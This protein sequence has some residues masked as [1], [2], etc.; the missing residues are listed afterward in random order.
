MDVTK[1]RP[2]KEA[3]M[4][5]GRSVHKASSLIGKDRHEECRGI[6]E[7]ITPSFMPSSTKVVTGEAVLGTYDRLAE[8]FQGLV[9]VYYSYPSIWKS[10]SGY[11]GFGRTE[12]VTESGPPKTPT[13]D[14]GLHVCLTWSPKQ[15]VQDI[16][17]TL[18]SIQCITLFR[19]AC[20]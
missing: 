1:F 14:L 2:C 9:G 7:E 3:R 11:A 18:E 5:W 15:Q 17:T 6:R 19:R 4:D 16:P 13:I 8:N 20:T 12:N 10:C